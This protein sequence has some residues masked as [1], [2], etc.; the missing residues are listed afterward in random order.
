MPVVDYVDNRRVHVFEC[1]VLSCKGKGKSAR[2]VRRY[3]DTGDAKSTSNLWRHAKGCWG[4]ET[5]DAAGET[6]DVHA[7]R[8]ALAKAKFKD[9]SITAAFERISKNRVTYSNRQHT[10]AESRYVPSSQE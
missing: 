1:G 10:K 8:D 6:K 7:A 9:G 2:H 4:Q 3:L 5:V